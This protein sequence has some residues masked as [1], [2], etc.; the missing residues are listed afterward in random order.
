M[1]PDVIPGLKDN[2]GHRNSMSLNGVTG[3]EDVGQQL[4]FIGDDFDRTRIK[5]S[6]SLSFVSI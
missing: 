5:R 3:M 1:L 6:R 4:R 2:E